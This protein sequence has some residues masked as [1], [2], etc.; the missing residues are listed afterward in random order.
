[1]FLLLAKVFQ[2]FKSIQKLLIN[3]IVWKKVEIIFHIMPS[4]SY[5]YELQFL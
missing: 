4:F 1:M 5:P 2:F 3:H